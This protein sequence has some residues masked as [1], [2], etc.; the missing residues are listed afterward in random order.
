[1][2]DG[3]KTTKR[4]KIRPTT[5]NYVGVILAAKAQQNILISVREFNIK[6]WFT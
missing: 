3:L 1:M 2:C 4:D 5:P 6:T